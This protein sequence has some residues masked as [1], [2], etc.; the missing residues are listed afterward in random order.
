MKVK[1]DIKRK[2]I[3]E[4]FLIRLIAREGERGKSG[5]KTVE[6]EPNRRDIMSGSFKRWEF[7]LGW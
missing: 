6:Q 1:K 5:A 3:V 4:L 7:F 2:K